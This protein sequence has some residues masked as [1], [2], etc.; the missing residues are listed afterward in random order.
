MTV[1]QYEQAIDDMLASPPVSDVWLGGWFVRA[2]RRGNP[3]RVTLF[4]NHESGVRVTAKT[5]EGLAV[6]MAAW[7]Q[8]R[9]AMTTGM[10]A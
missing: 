7:D 5:P 1:E 9:A 10:A 8:A 2:L 3:P 4:A 6:R